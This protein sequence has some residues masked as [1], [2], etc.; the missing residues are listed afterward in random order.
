VKSAAPRRDPIVKTIMY[1][2]GALILAGVLFN[3]LGGMGLING[4][5]SS[6]PSAK[7]SFAVTGN[8]QTRVD[9]APGKKTD[10]ADLSGTVTN[11]TTR[12]CTRTE[13]VGTMLDQTGAVVTITV[14]AN[15]ATDAGQTAAWKTTVPY[16][17]QT[18]TITHATWAALCG[19]SP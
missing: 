12:G 15:V 8:I 9:T 18:N 16:V 6:S 7:P 4:V 14:A 2:V 17:A 3:V 10:V 5:G 1:A 11:N 19:D 13:I